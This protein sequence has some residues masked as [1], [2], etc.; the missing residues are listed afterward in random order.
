MLQ[1]YPLALNQNEGLHILSKW[2]KEK[3]KIENTKRKMENAWYN[4]EKRDNQ[5]K[6]EKKKIK[7]FVLKSMMFPK[8]NA[9]GGI[10]PYG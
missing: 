9:I 10:W 3:R 2:G 4:Q 6:I 8:D 1:K 5:A 7:D